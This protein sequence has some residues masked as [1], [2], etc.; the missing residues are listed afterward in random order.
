MPTPPSPASEAP[1]AAPPVHPESVPVVA[2]PVDL[3]REFTRA[4]QVARQNEQPPVLVRP[5][6]EQRRINL[7]YDV[8][9][10]LLGRRPRTPS[11][12]P[13]FVQV[14]RM[15]G[16]LRVDSA[17]PRSAVRIEVRGPHTE[18][19]A[20]EVP[21]KGALFD[22]DGSFVGKPIPTIA[23]VDADGVPVALGPALPPD[24][25]TSTR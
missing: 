17:V 22:L 23:F 25:P 3:L 5:S 6:E 19:D 7:G 10:S 18:Y 12:E 24:S 1:Q 14:T 9:G 13:V 8:L 4:L 21:P 15:Q 16:G 11:S 20:R 2:V